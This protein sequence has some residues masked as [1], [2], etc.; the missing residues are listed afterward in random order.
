MN[1][2][3][4]EYD[5]HSIFLR[6]KSNEMLKDRLENIR[7]RRN[8][9]LPEI[10]SRSVFKS[11]HESP[12]KHISVMDYGKKYNITIIIEKTYEINL[13]NKRLFERLMKIKNKENTYVKPVGAN[14]YQSHKKM[15]DTIQRRLALEKVSLENSRLV[16]RINKL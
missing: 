14:F 7:N 3:S 15:Y 16:N 13:N 1:T 8:N 2:Y 9:F 11:I 10:K 6:Q 5:S 12:K 4:I